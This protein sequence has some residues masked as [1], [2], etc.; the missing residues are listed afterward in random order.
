M[1][2]ARDVVI[3]GGGHNGLVAAFYLARAGRRPLVL[4]RR[5]VVGGAAITDEFHPGFRVSTLGALCGPLRPVVAA[6][7]RLERHGLQ[8]IESDTRLFAPAPDGR[9]VLLYGDARRSAEGIARLSGHDAE[10]YLEFQQAL[11]R[12]VAAVDGL[13]TTTPPDIERPTAADLW[14]LLKT[15][16][17]VRGLET[18]DFYRLLRWAPMAVADLVAEFFDTDL[19]RAALAGRGVFGTFLGPW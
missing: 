10:R 12:I 7:M 2:A 1:A 17:R 9:S 19:L 16:R 11:T 5:P 15:G 8:M 4:E 14:A 6:D 3:I 13:L 18:R